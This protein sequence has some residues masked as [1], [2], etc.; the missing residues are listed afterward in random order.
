MPFSLRKIFPYLFPL[1]F[2]AA[3][4]PVLRF[5]DI[6][7]ADFTFS[8][9]T[10]PQSI[11]PA[12]VTGAPE[13]RI[14]N[15]LF[16]G[17][18]RQ[19]P[20]PEDSTVMKPT[21]ALASGHTLSE[22]KKTYTFT[23]RDGV[24]WSDGTPITAHDWAFSWQ[25]FLHPETAAEYAYQ[26]WYLTNGKKYTGSKVEVGDKVEIELDDRQ[27]PDQ[28][29]PRGTVLSGVLNEIEEVETGELNEDGNPEIAN[30]Y[31]V[32]MKPEAKGTVNWEASG[33]I[34]KF[35]K[36]NTPEKIAKQHQADNVRQILI[37]FSEVG[38]E[39]VDDKTLVVKL[40][41]PTPYFLELASFYPLYP[42]QRECVE[43]HGFPNWTKKENI[44]TSGPYLLGFR[45]LRECIRLERNPG[46]WDVGAVKL[47]IID[48]LA[49]ESDTTIL[50]MYLD[51]QLDWG[52]T[53]PNAAI[54]KLIER[55]A[56]KKLEP[57]REKERDEMLIAPMLTIYF[58][59][60]NT[61]KPPLDDPR[62]RRAINLAINKQEIVEFVTRA[63]QIPANSFVP[64]GLPGYKG[65]H[66]GD[67]NPEAARKL[68]AEAGYGPG[69]KK[70]PKF[71]IVYNTNEGHR[72]IAEV[73]QSQLQK[74]LSIEVGLKN[75]EWGAFLTKTHDMDYEMARAGWIAD[76]PD[77]NTFLDMFVTDGE[78]NQTNW[79]NKQ[80]DKLIADAMQEPDP[81]KRLDI[82]SEAEQILMD[83][84]P[85]AP[86]YYYVSLNLVRPY[87]KNF[88]PNTVDLHPLHIIEID[89]E[90][91]QKVLK[92]EGLR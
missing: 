12:K 2:I 35:T 51:G 92:A 53:V 84:Q 76:Y 75:L 18:Y 70:F 25:R 60:M 85:I 30:I 38:V 73:I 89:K 32:E 8:N 20:D 43:K 69:G 33:E 36:I 52:Y 79:S 57:G 58:Y 78:N 67:Y 65:G 77:P 16:E 23:I 42:V 19:L 40:D 72:D 80:Y 48:A 71:E 29:Y 87:V 6:P 81:V 74:N 68:L 47:K 31:H 50:N 55:D 90:L 21:P 63:G 10:E 26:L 62:V 9:G 39:A 24:A 45:K 88:Y 44:V 4:I 34:R 37:H 86:I 61:E 82:L 27:Y 59:R 64:Q 56:E 91:K 15:A 46:Y 66:S 22:D 11:D 14:I 41:N 54:K 17:L 28:H 1:F 49:V 7:P 5:E 13:G 83:E 3:L